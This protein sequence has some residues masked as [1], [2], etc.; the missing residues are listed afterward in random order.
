MPSNQDPPRGKVRVLDRGLAILRSFGPGNSWRTNGEISSATGLPRPTVS[1]LTTN[2]KTLG[3]L[4]YSETLRKYRLGTL[5]LALGFNTFGFIDVRVIAR[6]LMQRLADQIG[7]PVLLA[8]R[9]G[10]AMVAAEVC[11]CQTGIFN[12]SVNVGSR[13]S[14]PFSASGFALLAAMTPG[15]RETAM[16]EIKH[17]YMNKWAELQTRIHDAV[18]QYRCL[19]FCTALGSL[20][21]GI[22]GIALAIDTPGAPHSYTMGAAGPDY[23]FPAT[24]LEGELGPKLVAIKRELEG[25]LSDLAPPVGD[26]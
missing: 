5:V 6:P 12:L 2:L 26:L 25:R 1:R 4:E 24:T 8:S 13:L 19:G 22:N 15:E 16:E 23:R 21:G 20:E 18:E 14:L 9:D 17:H 11:Q 7:A 10:M 3:Y